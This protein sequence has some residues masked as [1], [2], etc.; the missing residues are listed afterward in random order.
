ME[1]ISYLKK[2]D[3]INHRLT[4]F[5]LSISTQ[6]QDGLA[7]LRDQDLILRA[8]R[9]INREISGYSLR[10]LDRASTLVEKMIR[11][12][13]RGRQLNQL[14][15]AMRVLGYN[16]GD[17]EVA[18]NEVLLKKKKIKSFSSP[19]KACIFVNEAL[20]SAYA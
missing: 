3:K 15:E 8:Q 6:S 9:R 18:A 17:L 7:E 1:I 12:G 20:L 4:I 11:S 10:F 2:I 14:L 19:V 16:I 13:Q 5:Y